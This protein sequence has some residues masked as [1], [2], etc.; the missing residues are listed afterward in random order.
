VEVGFDTQIFASNQTLT[1]HP[2]VNP[3]HAL[4]KT[5]FCNGPSCVN[6]IRAISLYII[7]FLRPFS[8]LVRLRGRFLVPACN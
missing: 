2:P 5:G 6:P 8:F 7:V 3:C 1:L 4:N